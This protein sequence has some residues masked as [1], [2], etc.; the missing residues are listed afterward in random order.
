MRV[1]AQSDSITGEAFKQG[2]LTAPNMSASRKCAK[3]IDG[4]QEITGNV[5]RGLAFAFMD[6]MNDGKEPKAILEKVDKYY[7]VGNRIE[8]YK[9]TE[10]YLRELSRF[11]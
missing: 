11:A 3:Y 8:P 4:L 1:V 9:D 5:H 7:Q 10:E 6:L 2:R